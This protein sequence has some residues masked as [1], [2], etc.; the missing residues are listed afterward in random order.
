MTV[1]RKVFAASAFLIT[2]KEMNYPLVTLQKKKKR[3]M[4][5]VLKII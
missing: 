3:L 5:E 2:E 4:I 1:K